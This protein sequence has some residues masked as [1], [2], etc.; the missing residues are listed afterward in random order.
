MSRDD[1]IGNKI[2]SI[3]RGSK[4][5]ASAAPPRPVAIKGLILKPSQ[6]KD[7]GVGSPSVQRIKALKELAVSV[8]EKELQEGAAESVLLAIKD[9]FEPKASRD[10]RHVALTFMSALV[11]GQGNTVAHL[12]EHIFLLVK[13]LGTPEDLPLCLD[14][15]VALTDNGRTL[16][17]IESQIGEL[18]VSWQNTFALFEKKNEFL[19]L[20]VNVIKYNVAYLDEARTVELLRDTCH[21]CTKTKSEDDI[22]LCLQIIE[23][24][25]CYSYL[26]SGSLRH[27][28]TTLCLILT[29]KSLCDLAWKLMRKLLGTHLGHAAVSTLCSLLQDRSREHIV[30]GGGSH[31][32]HELVARGAVFMLGMGLW[33]TERVT[34]LKH[35][36]AAILPSLL[37]AVECN[38]GIVSYEVAMALQR[39]VRCAGD[40]Q[41]AVVWDLVLDLI[42]GLFAQVESSQ[43]LTQQ[44]GSMIKSCLH[45]ILT[46]IE[47]LHEGGHFMSVLGGGSERL[48]AIIEKHIAVR[49]PN[50]VLRLLNHRAQ[51]CQ[52]S[53]ESW[54]D[55]LSQLM[56]QY[57]ACESRPAIR[58]KAL[59]VLEQIICNNRSLFE[60]EIISTVVLEQ[61]KMLN[62]ED[63]V[64]IRSG[65][66]KIII[67]LVKTCTSA[68]GLQLL[69]IVEKV[70]KRPRLVEPALLPTDSSGDAAAEGEPELRD[71]YCCA[72]G[73]ID[74][75]KEKLPNQGA[76][77]LLRIYR[78]LISHVSAQYRASSRVQTETECLVKKLVFDLLLDVR[79]DTSGRLGLLT[80][81]GSSS[82][83]GIGGTIL[84][85]PQC[86]V[87]AVS[88]SSDAP[89]SSA[90][91]L[92]S[93]DQLDASP[94]FERPHVALQYSLALDV[95]IECL[96]KETD[97]RV[98][99]LVLDKM[100]SQWQ[101]K[102]LILSACSSTPS[103]RSLPLGGGGHNHIELVCGVLCKMVGQNCQ[104]YFERLNHRPST[105]SCS[106]FHSAIFPLLTC[107]ASYH[108]MLSSSYQIEL[109]KCLEFGLKTKN[110]RTCVTT[111]SVCALEMEATMTRQLPAV[112]QSLLQ[113]TATKAMAVSIL[114]FL[115]S[116]VKLPKLYKNFNE[117]Q[118][119]L[120]FAIAL[121]YTDPQR[122]PHFAV[123]LAHHVIAMWFVKCRVAY[124]RQ[125]VSYI[126]QGLKSNAL[127]QFEE[128]SVRASLV[129]TD[130]PSKGLSRSSSTAAAA[131]SVS[132]AASSGS[133]C[134][135]DEKML[136]FHSELAETCTDLMS[137][138]VY[139][140][141]STVPKRTPVSEFL[142]EGGLS[143]TWLIGN[144]LVTITTSGGGVKATRTGLCSRCTT[145]VRNGVAASQSVTATITDD[146]AA[147]GSQEAGDGFGSKRRRHR[148]AIGAADANH[149]TVVASASTA[150]ITQS[151]D[152]LELHR[153]ASREHTFL[154]D[155]ANDRGDQ[156]VLLS[157]GKAVLRGG[158][159]GQFNPSYCNCWCNDWA[160]IYIRR[161][162]GS[163]S[164]VMRIQNRRL[165]GSEESARLAADI[166]SLFAP[167]APP[168]LPDSETA[169]SLRRAAVDTESI[170]ESD[171]ASLHA[172]HFGGGGGAA[173]AGT[174]S[175]PSSR[176]VS[177]VFVDEELALASAATIAS[178][179]DAAQQKE[180]DRIDHGSAAQKKSDS[181]PELANGKEGQ[182]KLPPNPFVKRDVARLMSF[183]GSTPKVKGGMHEHIHSQRDSDADKD[184]DSADAGMVMRKRGHTISA[185]G[186]SGSPDSVVHGAH[187]SVRQR[188]DVAANAALNPSFV[189][190]QLYH[191]GVLRA[192]D[193][194]M[195]V[196]DGKDGKEDE[197]ARA[198]RNL[199]RI[200]SYE[201]HKVGVV[202]VGPGQANDEGAILSNVY[203]S[204][205][206]AN[207]LQHLG[208]LVRLRD[209]NPEHVFTGGL[210]TESGMDG[211]YA[212]MWHDD[213]IQMIFHVATMMPHREND[214]KCN[215]KK[216]HIGN[217]YVTIVYNDG[218]EPY[219]I[220]TIKGNFNYV[221]II[222]Q[223]LDLV[224]NAVSVQ[225]D[226][227]IAD[228]VGQ[229]DTKIVSDSNLGLLVREMA[230]HSS[231]ASLILVHMKKDPQDPF[232]SNWLER[233]RQLK[234]IRKKI[235]DRS[236]SQSRG[237]DLEGIDMHDFT[238]YV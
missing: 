177:A 23:A 128:K 34:S 109:I 147:V 27:V 94:E 208:D 178:R 116:L 69:D 59:D 214:T 183:D 221:S 9:L 46:C 83:G 132:A 169:A 3:F 216:R 65:G 148:S 102:V 215:N 115:S 62:V 90:P 5:P 89:S 35:S 96:Q 199:D 206:Y 213:I 153:H 145:A 168:K 98:L 103:S 234:R 176:R 226:R 36:A 162:S 163:V 79:A 138:Y 230:L 225:T 207:F 85:S 182:E 227:D 211:E 100:T 171:Y 189:F 200:P 203:G 174:G 64:K 122:F 18:L 155:K 223:P 17:H 44:E 101:N 204:E 159:E 60:D 110:A 53:D 10:E 184:D 7:L 47:D 51:T 108:A 232:A 97:W 188:R 149:S 11:K 137:R 193:I 127:Q 61:M 91:A 77:H 114:T 28:T 151:R 154:D 29:V 141:C 21:I 197:F 172:M 2:K 217:D 71:L 119:K 58:M 52:P 143:Q 146:A 156:D 133:L 180:V 233:L 187:D 55:N 42:E 142:L 140:T 125:F 158:S 13:S 99:T 32:Q 8:Q 57:F 175:G 130:E 157:L 167:G 31:Q 73:L 72:S 124:R 129:V 179:S 191:S 82:V 6:L 134:A 228:I 126:I 131:V 205:R 81:S 218:T 45:D 161:P 25:L 24:M 80:R 152:D 104:K 20:V 235:M 201:T 118:Y 219:S 86:V 192:P 237:R 185:L 38:S 212:Y 78:M 135:A 139:A 209:C 117:Q 37:K 144:K 170:E 121:S 236:G 229:T 1:S 74:V 22:K 222:I 111:L 220:G 54:L 165:F 88:L 50:S 92:T 68:C 150:G 43:T 106:D 12:R 194:P 120:I 16:I 202:Y 87:S 166:C 67:D 84:Y 33:G 4:Q 26:P 190:L 93:A 66:I 75:F 238:D 198:V 107:M 56:N 19:N 224:S 173:A 15:L 70:M 112:L 63:A 95:I 164:W 123:Y 196:P 181:L 186:S 76:D 231:M 105:L 41:P 195:L 136:L 210:D 160:E 39:L 48:F 49:P 40:K 14:I 113:I 30:T